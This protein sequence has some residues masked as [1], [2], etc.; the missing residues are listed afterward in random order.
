MKIKFRFVII[1]IAFLISI[2]FA[3]G[4][5]AFWPQ[6]L[7]LSPKHIAV[8]IATTIITFFT[9][10]SLGFSIN[11]ERTTLLIRVVAFV[12][13]IFGFISVVLLSIFAKNQSP[14][15]IILGTEFLVYVLIIYSLTKSNQ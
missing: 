3:Y 5:Y 10:G 11:S 6:D 15:I 1:I 2:L 13:F 4:F 14:V 8:L 7:L 12:F 9:L